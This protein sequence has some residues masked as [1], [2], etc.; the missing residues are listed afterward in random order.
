MVSPADSGAVQQFAADL[1]FAEHKQITVL[2]DPENTFL[3]L[4]GADAFPSIYAYNKYHKL[5]MYFKGGAKM[6][7]IYKVMHMED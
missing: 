6:Q 4:F 3:S 2:R 7:L 1:R 5:A